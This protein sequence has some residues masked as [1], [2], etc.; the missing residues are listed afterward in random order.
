MRILFGIVCFLVGGVYLVPATVSLGHYFA[1]PV[2]PLWF[3]LAV[4]C[5]GLGWWIAGAVLTGRR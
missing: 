5:A 1:E 3:V 2:A 4:A